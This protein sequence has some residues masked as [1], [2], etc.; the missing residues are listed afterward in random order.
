MQ[1]LYFA[2]GMNTNRASMA[3]RCPA[4]QPLGA[5]QLLAHRFRFA[6]HADVQIDRRAVTD[7]VLWSITEPC[8]ISLDTLE[9]YPD[10]YDRKWAEVLHNYQR[11]RALVYFMQP[12]N[13]NAAPSLGYFDMVCEGYRD[14]AVPQDQLWKSVTK[15]TMTAPDC[16][17]ILVG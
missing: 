7:G 17:R 10:Y 11:H 1:I 9:G 6:H 2:Y 12:G 15:S 16:A 4:A 13:R 3:S 14:F 8:L 5:A